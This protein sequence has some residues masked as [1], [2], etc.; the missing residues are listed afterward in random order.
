[1]SY[2]IMQQKILNSNDIYFEMSLLMI[3]ISDHVM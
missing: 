3:K 1:M 2:G